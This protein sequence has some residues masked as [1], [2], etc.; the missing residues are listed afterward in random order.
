[1]SDSMRLPL[2]PWCGECWDQIGEADSEPPDVCPD[3]GSDDTFM[4]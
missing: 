3:C 1:M 4:I 2:L